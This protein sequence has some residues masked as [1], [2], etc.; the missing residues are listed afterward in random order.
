MALPQELRLWAEQINIDGVTNMP[1]RRSLSNAEFRDGWLYGQT[2]S[3]Q[4]LNQIL[5]LLTVYSNSSPAVP[6]L[7]PTAHPIPGIALEMNG[8]ATGDNEILTDVYGVSLPDISGDAPTGFT[9][10]VRQA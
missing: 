3:A 6:T 10:I 8:Q 7:F 5:Y 1:Q 9:Y 4:Q 2:I